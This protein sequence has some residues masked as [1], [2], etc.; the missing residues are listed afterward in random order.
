MTRLGPRACLLILLCGI[1]LLVYNGGFHSVDEI[2]LFATAQTLVEHGELHNN[3]VAWMPWAMPEAGRSWA[4]GPDGNVYPKK[5]PLQALLAV[6]FYLLARTAAWLDLVHTSLLPSVLVAALS[7]VAV[8]ELGR[9]LG[10]PSPR[11]LQVALLFGL[12]TPAAVYS[13]LFFTDPL[14]GLLLAAGLIPLLPPGRRPGRGLALSGALWGLSV[15]AS[16]PSAFAVLPLLLYGLWRAERPQGWARLLASFGLG[17]APVPLFNWLRFGSVLEVGYQLAQGE[18]F[19]GNPVLGIY[20]VLLSPVR[21][22]LFYS[23]IAFLGLLA[24]PLLARRDRP[25]ALGVG[26]S[27]AAFL[28]G[29]GS[30]YAWWGGAAWGPRFLVTVLPL[31]M[32]PFT[33]SWPARRWARLGLAGM[34]LVSL[35]VQIPGTAVSFVPH[36]LALQ[37]RHLSYAAPDLLFD[38]RSSPILMQAAA[39]MH[40]PLDL[41]WR[42]DA[43]SAVALAALVGSVLATALALR[44]LLSGLSREAAG[45]AVLGAGLL[46][47]GAVVE[48]RLLALNTV[49]DAPAGYAQLLQALNRE[50]PPS[51]GVVAL[52]SHPASL[53]LNGYRSR[54]PLLTLSPE[55][56]GRHPAMEALLARQAAR[57]EVWLV[58]ASWQRPDESNA[59]ERWLLTRTYPLP[60]E[61]LGDYRLVRFLAAEAPRQQPSPVRWPGAAL[62]AA[63]VRL[64]PERGAVLVDLLWQELPTDAGLQLFVHLV[65]E[66][67]EPLA[68]RDRKPLEGL[69]LD[70]ASPVHDRL[71]IELPR[72][73]PPGSYGVILGWYRLDTLGRVPT[74]SGQ[75]FVELGTLEIP[76]P[77]SRALRPRS[78]R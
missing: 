39:L 15:S 6:P 35:A 55:D 11:A 36:E 54:A 42:L 61:T 58:A 64:D 18:G 66:S 26:A 73:L 8:F 49:R 62:E 77:T 9:R 23:P 53:L 43:P 45:S 68:Q 7:A 29:T 25:L 38:P 52:A 10:A 57:G 50:A 17:L 34:A 41:P 75:E 71:A 59:V 74:L 56:P 1:Y 16:L 30:W 31:V 67:L 3:Q 70:R 19:G 27:V 76:A 33:V 2:S 21:G 12:A 46:A 51:V 20:G 22:L 24:L 5:P 32:L 14:A 48:L 65:G 40:G 72:E 28:M 37:R 69:P 60:E 44:H 13:K 63:A 4:L 47:L 78:A